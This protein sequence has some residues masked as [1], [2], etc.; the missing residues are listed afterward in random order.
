MRNKRT[1]AYFTPE[2]VLTKKAG[3][4]GEETREGRD[5]EA[6]E[7]RAVYGA[8]GGRAVRGDG[9]GALSLGVQGRARQAAGQAAEPAVYGARAGSLQAVLRR[10][11]RGAN[12]AQRGDDRENVLRE[13]R[14]CYERIDKRCMSHEI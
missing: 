4:G 14:H 10:A 9:A 3:A 8:N 1:R 13:R 12:S 2:T 5:R 6:G 11:G 7:V